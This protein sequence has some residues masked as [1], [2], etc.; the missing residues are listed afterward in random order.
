MRREP[1]ELRGL[2]IKQR[3]VPSQ[4]LTSTKIESIF[5]NF[6]EVFDISYVI[7]ITSLKEAWYKCDSEF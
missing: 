1:R 3:F 2:S 7:S 4:P 6:N 5:G